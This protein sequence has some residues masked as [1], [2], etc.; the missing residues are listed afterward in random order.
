MLLHTHLD[1]NQEEFVN[2]SMTSAQVLLTVL[3]DI[4]S[5]SKLDAD[6]VQL[7]RK[8]FSLPRCM[9]QCVDAV[10]GVLQNKSS[11]GS[12]SAVELVMRFPRHCPVQVY[13]D[14]HHLSQVL[15]KYET[16][17]FNSQLNEC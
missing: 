15:I 10:R 12:G 13:G 3:N 2:Y 1:P 9:E 4:L 17:C 8:Y 5:L 7:E 6:K 14:E 16:V 11:S